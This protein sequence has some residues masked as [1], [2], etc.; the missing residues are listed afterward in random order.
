MTG[1]HIPFFA[2][3]SKYFDKAPR[4]ELKSDPSAPETKQIEPLIAAEPEK[5]DPEWKET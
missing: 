2:Q 3:V 4:I 1:E 5:I